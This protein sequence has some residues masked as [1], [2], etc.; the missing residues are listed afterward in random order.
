MFLST[1]P[2]QPGLSRREGPATGHFAVGT[3]LQSGLPEA[4]PPRHRN[5]SGRQPEPPAGRPLFRSVVPIPSYA[6]LHYLRALLRT[7]V[8]STID[9]TQ[10][11]SREE[12]NADNNPR[13]HLLQDRRGVRSGRHQQE[14]LLPLAPFPR[15]RGREHRRQARMAPV[16]RIR[17][18][19]V[20]PEGKPHQHSRTNR[21]LLDAR[22]SAQCHAVAGEFTRC[23]CAETCVHVFTT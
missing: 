10:V 15:S 3:A 22:K 20:V 14:H 16:Q 2:F 17:H 21:S 8:P 5:R 7:P 11:V 6:H 9:Y 1:P 12:C 23:D 18:R 4:A 13:M 19:A